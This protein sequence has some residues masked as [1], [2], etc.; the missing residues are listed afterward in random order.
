M[1]INSISVYKNRET[2]LVCTREDESR[3]PHTLAHSRMPLAHYTMYILCTLMQTH[4]N[5]NRRRRRAHKSKILY[6]ILC[7]YTH[8]WLDICFCLHFSFYFHSVFC[9]HTIPTM[10]GI[11]IVAAYS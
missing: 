3:Q 6:K 10:H 8:A 5:K 9:V 11:H 4:K 7:R 2:G 1:Y